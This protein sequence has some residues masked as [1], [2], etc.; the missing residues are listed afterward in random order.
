MKFVCVN[1]DDSAS[2]KYYNLKKKLKSSGDFDIELIV[3]N[4]ILNS[5]IFELG[6]KE[7]SKMVR[8]RYGE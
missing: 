4:E 3:D 6:L 1:I 8:K 2:T 5:E 7:F